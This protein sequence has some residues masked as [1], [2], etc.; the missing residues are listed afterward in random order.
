MAAE[1]EKLNYWNTIIKSIGY[2][3]CILFVGPDSV[4]KAPGVL[5][6]EELVKS[7]QFQDNEFFK[8]IPRDEMFLLTKKSSRFRLVI[9]F[10]DYI[11]QNAFYDETYKK[12]TSIPFKTIIAV[13]RYPFLIESFKKNNIN[14][15]HRWFS[16]VYDKS[17]PVNPIADPS[18]EKPLVYNLFGRMDNDDSLLLTH[19]DLFDYLTQLLSANA[20][21]QELQEIV[22][23]SV[24]I[25]F[26]GFKFERWYV[27]LLLRLFKLADQDPG[28]ER[29]SISSGDEEDVLSV[30]KTN[31]QM[32]FIDDD[33][34]SFINTL[35]DKC[36]ESGLTLRT[37]SVGTSANP[38]MDE[39]EVLIRNNK[40]EDALKKLDD[41]EKKN[42]L[43]GSVT[44][45][46]STWNAIQ[47]NN[48]AGVY[49]PDEL[50]RETN[51]FIQRLQAAIKADVD[52]IN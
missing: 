32:N 50:M 13:T 41:F 48:T 30:C 39:F 6:H 23:Q 27:Q 9:N 10:K 37:P 51:R 52:Q 33:V 44:V 29:I 38:V 18:A 42:K 19:N 22:N 12:I 34:D 24:E 47:Q 46:T 4:M 8:Y 3:T 15:E 11:Q 14:F 31:F 16:K 26:L 7:P 28:N 20:I 2:G 1:P 45:L 35:Y 36:K 40:F 43:N 25:I 49:S 21:P 17:M 5:Y